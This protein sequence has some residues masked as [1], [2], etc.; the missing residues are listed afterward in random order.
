[1][2]A[3]FSRRTMR[4]Y[5][6][7]LCA[8]PL[9]SCDRHSAREGLKGGMKICSSVKASEQSPYEDGVLTLEKAKWIEEQV[10]RALSFHI[11]SYGLLSKAAETTLGW[12]FGI[13]V[14]AAGYIASHFSDQPWRITVPIIFATAATTFE[15]AVLIRGTM[16]AEDVPSP[17]N[18]AKNISG[19][20]DERLRTKEEG[21]RL[22]EARGLDATI[23]D[24]VALN[25]RSRR[26][27]LG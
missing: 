20:E 17:G 11:E 4:P 1:M 22:T 15:A 14:G 24:Y 7:D 27:P 5:G 19:D 9:R 6:N 23:E 21:M 25:A 13:A 12:L 2:I 26:D 3:S 10:N 18:T 8:N 16:F